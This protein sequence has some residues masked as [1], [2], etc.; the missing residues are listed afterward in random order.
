M[1]VQRSSA[2]SRQVAWAGRRRAP[3]GQAR[4]RAPGGQARQ[5]TRSQTVARARGVSTRSS[6]CKFVSLDSI[7]GTPALRS[8]ARGGVGEGIG[9][10]ATGLALLRR[11]G[12]VRVVER[13]REFRAGVGAG[14]G[15][16]SN[17][18]ACLASLGLRAGT[19][20]IGH[21][22]KHHR[23]WNARFDAELVSAAH[24]DHFQR[25]FARFGVGLYGTLR[26]ELVG[27]LS[28]P[29][30]AE[31]RGSSTAARWSRCAQ[32]GA[33]ANR[34]WWSCATAGA[35]RQ[36]S[37]SART[38]C[39]ARCCSWSSRGLRGVARGDPGEHLLRRHPGRRGPRRRARGGP[40][41]AVPGAH[42]AA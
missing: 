16:S 4:R 5:G 31:G 37:L 1:R 17:G 12:D 38:A 40:S 11:G 19:D 39:T 3:G 15:L 14:F 41:G 8:A 28:A 21:R 23:L 32:G 33:E 6:S 26:S 24:S 7:A 18:Y 35:T 20:L 29:L 22:L 34:L 42:A 10:L 27:L 2:T 9:G 13:A 30:E 36:T 25:L